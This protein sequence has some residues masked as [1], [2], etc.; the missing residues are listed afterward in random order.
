MSLSRTFLAAALTSA[1]LAAHAQAPAK[2]AAPAP[3]KSAAPA[4]A[5]ATATAPA[6]AAPAEAVPAPAAPATA[7]AVKGS[8]EAGKHKVHQCQGCHG[9]ADW[10]TAFP[11]VYRVPKLGGQKPEY[12]VAALKAY[13]NGER[14]FQTM[15]G[16][17]MDMSDQD[18][19]DIAAYY[20]AGGPTAVAEKK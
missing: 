2:G 17:A 12:I 16:M 7:V 1:A 4:P 14:D 13:R 18:M 5:A 11:E 19:A 8:A 9:I 20:G 15:R 6:P 3:A 10:K